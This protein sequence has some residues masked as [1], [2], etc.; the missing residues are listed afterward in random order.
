[1]GQVSTWEQRR[2][3]AVGPAVAF[4]AAGGLPEGMTRHSKDRK[5]KR[6]SFSHFPRCQSQ[7]SKVSLPHRELWKTNHDWQRAWTVK[8]P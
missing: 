8:V 1:M 3:T 4:V 2:P 5:E 7:P 6:E